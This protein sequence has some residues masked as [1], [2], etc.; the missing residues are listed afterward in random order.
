MQKSNCVKRVFTSFAT[1][2]MLASSINPVLAEDG[3]QATASPSPTSTASAEAV[4]TASASP[5][6]DVPNVIVTEND[7]TV[8]EAPA[9][10]TAEPSAS[11][12]VIDVAPSA[13]PT[14][15]PTAVSTATPEATPNAAGNI[16]AN[17]Y[18]LTED[19]RALDFSAA[20]LIVCV[21]DPTDIIDA[22]VVV[23]SFSGN[24]LLQFNSAEEAREAYGYYRQ[25][26]DFVEPDTLIV[27][28]TD[29]LST[30]TAVE[31]T[32]A[33]ADVTAD[34][35]PISE[36]KAEAG[37]SDDRTDAENATA[38]QTDQ[39]EKTSADFAYD[40]ALIDTGAAEGTDAQVMSVLGDDGIDRN[41]H[42][43]DMMAL[44]REQN[45][46][47]RVLSI[48]ALNDDGSGTVASVYAAMELAIQ[49]GARIINLSLAGRALSDAQLISQAVDDAAAA[50]ITVVGAAGN[51]G[52]DVKYY[53]PGQIESAVI[54]GACDD[55]GAKRAISNYGATVDYYVPA[56]T[57]S[58]A[59]S[60]F[61][62][63]LSVLIDADWAEA[64]LAPEGIAYKAEDVSDG[65]ED[66]SDA[67]GETQLRAQETT[68]TMEAGK[69]F[70]AD[71]TKLASVTSIK[72]ILPSEQAPGSDTTTIDISAAKDGS[73][74]AWFDS[75]TGTIY[76]HSAAS[77][78]MLNPDSQLMFQNLS[79]MTSVDLSRFNTKQVTNMMGMFRGCAA[80]TEVDASTFDTSKVINLGD[81]FNG[82]AK[83]TS[84]KLSSFDTS[85]AQYMHQMFMNC[86]NLKQIDISS[87]STPKLTYMGRM[88]Q[89]CT[90]LSKIQFG[91]NFTIPSGTYSGHYSDAV[92]PSPTA[93]FSGAKST[94]KWGLSS[95]MADTIYS[96]A[97]LNTLGK[98]AG[99]LSGAW[100][101]QREMVSYIIRYN[102][103]GGVN[104]TAN[105]TSY[106]EK[107][108]DI[109]LAAPTREGY[110]FVKWQDADGHTV[111][112]I[113][114]G[115]SAD[116]TLNAIWEPI[117]YS[118]SY[119]L[120]GGVL[121]TVFP[122]SYTIESADISLSSPAR[123]GYDFIGWQKSDGNIIT[124]IPSGSTGNLSLSALWKP[125]KYSITYELNGGQNN[126][127]N[128]S[129]HTIESE[130]IV[131]AA[132]TRTGYSFIKWQDTAGNEVKNIT[133]R[134]TG[135][136]TLTAIW[137]PIVYTITYELNGG[138]NNSANPSSYTIESADIIFEAPSR[139]QYDFAGWQDAD[140]NT[141]TCIPSGS[142]GNVTLSAVWERGSY[143]IAY[144]LNGGINNAANPT[145]YSMEA[146][147][148]KLEVP[149]RS[150]Y[151]FVSW[152]DADGNA[153]TSIPTGT[154]GTIKL[155]AA[156]EPI[157]YNVSYDLSG[158]TNN[159][160]NPSSYTIESDAI[161]LDEPTRSGY[162]F[163]GW[164]KTYYKITG[165]NS[166]VVDGM[167]PISATGY[168]IGTY[169]MDQNAFIQGDHYM[170]E[171]AVTADAG[172]KSIA[173][174]TLGR[175]E[176]QTT[177]DGKIILSSDNNDHYWRYVIADFNTKSE[178]TTKA[179]S[180]QK[181]NGEVLSSDEANTSDFAELHYLVMRPATQITEDSGTIAS[182]SQ[183]DI[184]F[185]AQW[186]PMME[187]G[188]NF[189][190]AI[191]SLV[192]G[193]SI[194]DTNTQD[195]TV[196]A[197]VWS[198]TQPANDVN[199]VDVSEAQDKSIV[200]WFDN[201]S[202]TVFLYS[203]YKTIY[204]NSDASSMFANFNALPS[205][206][207]SKFNAEKVQ[208]MKGM[209]AGNGAL[210][211]IT[212]GDHFIIPSGKY[213]GST[214]DHVFPTPATT[215]SGEKSNGKWGAA[216]EKADAVYSATE[217]NELGKSANALIG[218]W[219]AQKVFTT[220]FDIGANFNC[221][222]KKLVSG[223]DVFDTGVI[224]TTITAFAWSDTAPASSD[225][226]I[227]V[228]ATHDGSIKVWFD[229]ESGT[230]YLFS[231]AD[232]IYLN[233][234]SSFMFSN[235][236]AAKSIDMSRFDSKLLTN[237]SNM[238]CGCKALT[239][240]DVSKIDTSN[241]TDMSSM[242]EQCSTL[243]SLDVSGFNTSSATTMRR[244]FYLC[245]SVKTLDVSKWDTSNVTD[246]CAMFS[247]CTKLDTLDLSKF[248]T[249]NVTNMQ[250]MFYGCEGFSSAAGSKLDVSGFNTSKVTDMS[251]MFYKCD[252]LYTID[253]SGFDTSQV[254]NMQNMFAYC[255]MLG[256][257]GNV[258]DV[259][260]FDTGNVTDMQS[261]FFACVSLTTLDVSYFK[262]SNVTNMNN[263]FAD[264]IKLEA[265]NVSGFDT[266]NVTA[267]ASMF[268][269]LQRVTELD[270]SHFDTS[271]VTAIGW[272][273]YG[274]K[275]LQYL[276][277]SN[278]DTRN[279]Q[280]MTYM[281]G[282]CVDMRRIKCGDNFLIPQ[283]KYQ[284]GIFPSTNRTF[285]DHSTNCKW[286][287]ESET[288]DISY[289]P[290]EMDT[291]GK[292]PKALTGTWFTQ[293]WPFAIT[294]DAN[295]GT[296]EM[297]VQSTFDDLPTTLSANKFTKTGARFLNWNTAADGTGTAYTDK[298][299]VTFAASSLKKGTTLYAQWSVNQNLPNTGGR[300]I[301]MM[302][303][304]AAAAGAIG[305]LTKK[306]RRK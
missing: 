275:K 196:V 6:S 101:A 214:S 27:T 258:L 217:L 116:I 125:T 187:S 274:C 107:S 87:F 240:L 280:N 168:A 124:S 242:F 32:E 77:V 159:D 143:H 170:L 42:G 254:T 304:L 273:F 20:R 247:T 161:T 285:S 208:S 88:F 231:D 153:I 213:D 99:A 291:L 173:P 34:S 192:S 284:Y 81:M 51:D 243:T 7:G 21:N 93:T 225:N 232:Q 198:D 149:Y 182:G 248:D 137:E 210:N 219:Y 92:F 174:Y 207:V 30:E 212:F 136:V 91:E 229:S 139:E 300:G 244:M 16:Y 57:T 211:T 197:F 85:S 138:K 140:G 277:L 226:A 164:K 120:N 55:S 31:D 114:S 126:A 221:A 50:G 40:I 129:F 160:A 293:R 10:E 122:A 216:S 252:G 86:G 169:A 54:I 297:K 66:M 37:I 142:T 41:G 117:E 61:S 303:A 96:A 227:D 110:T 123:T 190:C 172:V 209:F 127:A 33:G 269:D 302:I 223:K 35:N 78:I 228:S 249:A 104:N 234:D 59:A 144:E 75:S 8:T 176:S 19:E 287:L 72:A 109:T 155:T 29:D 133:A 150:G 279:V 102:L 108:P 204:F 146:D 94:G 4:S 105:P 264:C 218:T 79:S 2:V 38:E 267:M 119:E 238:F 82:C 205:I 272:M 60:L 233:S 251:W 202:N 70:N 106:T 141:V 90:A 183:Y 301:A 235:F 131:L 299:L 62:G 103:F 135:N 261:M 165:D 145:A 163:A 3:D 25:G 64:I 154:T 46:D 80:I 193:T 68:A 18:Q 236:S 28:A 239:S 266:H 203:G 47:A 73:I 83:L 189:N 271:R 175:Y 177:N 26:A 230:I 69:T 246:M 180:W 278:F 11:A 253:V 268:Q 263:M 14:A 121:G 262:T 288:A 74:L 132:P 36:F 152:H 48:K 13:T 112:I 237:T 298:D 22:S 215:A 199:V 156:W 220:T 97:E 95:E 115:S 185:T 52:R 194:S 257:F 158:G 65:N 148:L 270:V 23:D 306:K 157:K 67:S 181:F 17:D 245:S 9:V 191:K 43:S 200:A 256:E 286:G 63:C 24:Y 84:V 5:T 294:F 250:A 296:G 222:I 49:S 53:V 151:S 12:D 201:T 162:V 147:A 1:A 281:M 111:T 134:S 171:T 186:A 283:T 276:D 178:L 265:L 167:A 71:I 98:T 76:W 128:P 290:T 113:P 292:T 15:S 241:V 56:E 289:S 224:D 295:G 305:E 100:Y 282:Y 179:M 206:D 195:T 166:I 188:T 39:A 184:T 255:S 260:H 58:E 89:G 44:I 259:S 118:I 130:E 45:P